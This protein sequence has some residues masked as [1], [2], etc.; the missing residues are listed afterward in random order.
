MHTDRLVCRNVAPSFAVTRE[1]LRVECP[2]YGG[3]D[4]IYV[5]IVC[6]EAVW[7]LDKAASAVVC[8]VL[9]A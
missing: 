6:V 4:Q 8:G 3:A 9:Y 1:Q 7:Y 5:V 2:R